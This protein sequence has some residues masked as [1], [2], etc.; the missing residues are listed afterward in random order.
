MNISH[1]QKFDFQL[2]PRDPCQLIFM[3]VMAPLH[4]PT[5]LDI[6]KAVHLMLIRRGNISSTIRGKRIS[7]GEGECSLIGSWEPHGTLRRSAMSAI[8]INISEDELRR[9]LFT[10]GNRL[11]A[12]LRSDP[13]ARMQKL[14]VSA[15]RSLTH[16]LG[17]QLEAIQGKPDEWT[18]LRQWHAVCG[19]FIELET[20]LEE[21][22]GGEPDRRLA[23]ALEL[24][25]RNDGHPLS[26]AEAAA[27]CSFSPSRFSH[28]FR[29]FFGMSF[30]SYE[31]QYRLNRAAESLLEYRL[32]LKEIAERWGF[33][34]SAH[35]SR[36][37]KK[38]FGHTPGN[39]A[40]NSS[41]KR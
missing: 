37:F 11:W 22:A 19:F 5:F 41:R 10:G 31:L 14:N 39:F 21:D 1:C 35:F 32:S 38:Y 13:K 12:L 3:P 20:Y 34:D 27:A 26:V 36:C 17:D 24:L 18:L 15:I 7:L 33:F 8:L 4:V 25:H 29:E 9:F 16:A 6:H 30:G 40:V 2:S 23:P 28:L